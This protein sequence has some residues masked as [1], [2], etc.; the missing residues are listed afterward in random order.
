MLGRHLQGDK[1]QL[2]HLGLGS[3]EPEAS[4]MLTKPSASAYMSHHSDD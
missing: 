3:E 4:D 2:R 1:L